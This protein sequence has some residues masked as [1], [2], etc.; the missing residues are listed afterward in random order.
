[1]IV[2]TS[3]ANKV[4]KPARERVVKKRNLCLNKY[5]LTLP[6][7]L[8]LLFADIMTFTEF[9]KLLLTTK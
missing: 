8:G 4:I 5:K 1:M 3:T 7:T 6:M 2:G 9:T